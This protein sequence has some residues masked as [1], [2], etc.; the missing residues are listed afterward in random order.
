MTCPNTNSKEWKALMDA[1]ITPAQAMKDYFE[2]GDTIRT[3]KEVLDTIEK[4]KGLGGLSEK[5][6]D[7]TADEELYGSPNN[8]NAVEGIETVE[9]IAYNE[10]GTEEEMTDALID[11]SNNAA[12]IINELQA[13]LGIQSAFIT[14]AEAQEITANANNPYDG[15]PSFFYGDTVY[16][17]RGKALNP[18]TAFHEFSHP[19]VRTIQQTNKKL[20]D[21]LYKELIS[22]TEGQ[23]ILD[24]IAATKNL[25]DDSDMLQEEV[26]VRALAQQALNKRN[27]IEESSGF[28]KF[29][30]NLLYA[31]KQL[32][33][34]KYGKNIKISKLDES[35]TLEE[36][37]D[38][39]IA[40][41]AIT[42]PIN[43]I[44]RD[45]VVSYLRQRDD[46][47]AELESLSRSDAIELTR[48][49]YDISAKQIQSLLKRKEFEELAE[50]LT[51]EMNTGPIQK[52]KGNLRQFQANVESK[53]KTALE[54]I[55][56]D[57]VRLEAL[58]KS[59]LTLEVMMGKINTHMTE[60]SKEPD[61]IANMKKVHHYDQMLSYWESFIEEVNEVMDKSNV[62]PNSAIIKS[63]NNINRYLDRINN[64]KNDIYAD[65]ARETLYE[66]LEPIGRSLKQKY[67]NMLANLEEKNAP[68]WK[69]DKIAK[70]YY[71]LTQAENKRMESLQAKN[72][73][74][75]LSR[76][77]KLELQGLE[78]KSANGIAITREKIEALL[79]GEAGDANY[80]NS[81]FEGYLY[82][83]DPIVGGLALYVKN[84]MNQVMGVA[85]KKFN[86]FA[87]DIEPLL[88]AA[89]FN[90]RKIGDLGER[91]GF[92][93]IISTRDE[94]G[95]IIEKEVLT[96]LNP[97]KNW[98]YDYDVLADAVEKA[99]VNHSDQGTE[100]SRKEMIRAIA[101]FNDFKRKYMHD[102]FTADYY[103]R[104]E[105]FE[106]DEIGIE[107]AYRRKTIMEQINS[108]V[109][110][111]EIGEDLEKEQRLDMLW[112]EYRQLSSLYY[113]NG[114]P[115]VDIPE[116]GIF[117]K[118]IALRIKEYNE[119]TKGMY[120]QKLRKDVFEN[121][122][123]A[124]EI[125]LIDRGITPD[126]PT[127]ED[128]YNTLRSA[129]IDKNIV[130]KIKPEWFE[131]RKVILDNIAFI[132][133][134]LGSRAKADLD[135]SERW[136]KIFDLTA[137]FKDENGQPRGNQLDEGALQGIKDLQDEIEKIKSG[138]KGITGLTKEE[139]ADY[140]EFLS[141]ID[142]M[143]YNNFK[144]SRP[145]DFIKYSK[146]NELR[147]D[148]LSKEDIDTLNK[149][150][151]QLA[152][153]MSSSV[154]DDYVD[155]FNNFVTRF[156][157]EA[158]GEI[159]AVLGENTSIN[160]SNVNLILT[161]E[162][163]VAYLKSQS[164]EFSKWFTT[165]HMSKTFFKRVEGS[166]KGVEVTEYK[167]TY[168]WTVTKPSDEKYYETHT[169]VNSKGEEETVMGLPA[170]KYYASVLKS[171]FRTP[172]VVGETVDNR[173]QWLPRGKDEVDPENT[174]YINEKY[175]EMKENNKPLFELLEKLKEHHLENQ[176]GLNYRSRLYLDMPRYRKSNLEVWQTTSVKGRAKK[177]VNALTIWAQR[178]K[179][180]FRRTAD[181]AESG[182]NYQDEF[183][184]IR[185]DMFDNEQTSVP[186]SGLYDIDIG[187][188]S[189][190]I[191]TSMM[192]YML[193]AERQKALI[194]ASP[195][196]EAI[197]SVVKRTGQIK[198]PLKVNKETWLNRNILK[199][200]PKN[201]KG[202]K[203]VREK[204]IDNF[205]AREFEGETMTGAGANSVFL[206][207][208]ANKLF[209]RASFGFF[210]LNIPSALKNSYGAKFQGMI[211]ASAGKYY[212]HIEFQKGN[213]WSYTTMAEL[214][215]NN[216][217]YKKGPKSLRQQIMEIFDP[218]QDRFADKFGEGLSRTVLKDT[219]E[220]SWLYSPRKWVELQAT[221]QIFG[222][223]M[224]RQKVDQVLSDG[225]KKQLNYVDAWELNE[226][227]QIVLKQ[228]IDVRWNNTSTEHLMQD[229][230]T[231]E[232]IAE[233]Y[234]IPKEDVD[235]VFR[236]Y[237]IDNINE[238]VAK[239]EKERDE[240][241]ANVDVS[242]AKTPEE[243]QLL[244]D[245]IENIKS[246]HQSKIDEAKTITIK[247]SEFNFYKNKMQQVMNNLQG[248]YAK[249][250]QPEAQRYLAFRFLSYLRRYFTSMMVNRYGFSGSIWDPKPRLNPGMGDVQM[251]YYVQFLKTAGETVSK[252]GANLPYMNAEEKSAALKV[253]TEVGMLIS[254]PILMSALLGW[255]PDDEER[256]AKLREKSGALPFFMT[257]ADM[258][259][260]FNIGGWL[261]N[262]SLLL[263]YN[264]RTENEQFIPLPSMGLSSLTSMLDLKSIVFGPTVM[265]YKQIIEN[266]YDIATGG[267]K[268]YY[269]RTVGPYAWQQEGGN[270]VWAQFGRMLGLTGSSLD[271]AKG[272]KGIT[273]AQAMSK[274]K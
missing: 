119:L 239:I 148:K 115:K 225:T 176:K 6:L 69:K 162:S 68:Q 130:T 228:G 49:M 135:I 116:Q 153:M 1:G 20:F 113:L 230:E 63:I 89:G 151:N 47:F 165:N 97:H 98:R 259:R 86:S 50:F 82:S 12:E 120:D 191:T 248:T 93:D 7:T 107:A 158:L 28:K 81:F 263:L 201:K 235:E 73:S 198:D 244:K 231:F 84:E 200:L 128:Y 205:I 96:F 246:Y 274:A 124:Y 143:G 48:K 100:K 80:F 247:N 31:I 77:E 209:S 232:Q 217:L 138:Q 269:K 29:I 118:S 254:L 160:K 108:I 271:P 181:D 159:Q 204:A 149:L 19:F 136:K 210:A 75:G 13:R 95:N 238:K 22:T 178:V 42:I 103:K 112:R 25:S 229:G 11:D 227:K 54:K 131:Q 132:M 90:P 17:V 157:E 70:E 30:K 15:E 207:N 146:L 46:F 51:D 53:A 39:L 36:L 43:N 171:K 122:L 194:K 109:D 71:G 265:S 41:D 44:S 64:T 187:D 66:Q 197:Q 219:A 79:K 62:D 199:F 40:A 45:D 38:M 220:F 114:Q 161:N 8:L 215:F 268:S 88:K 14:E 188:V 32:F 18:E 190:D 101:D 134:K 3:P 72:K 250:D 184:L 78:V 185:A 213:A 260:P 192:R 256:F 2:H 37:A 186:I 27:N 105:L 258:D 257:N 61:S 33:R 140:R 65:G 208:F 255:D 127:T 85:Q 21:R 92:R 123:H 137:G 251:G 183:N 126:N 242:T 125:S 104:Q 163:L 266:S 59:V 111:V 55:Q 211:E 74:T 139:N 67:E 23:Q 102:E 273:T 164:P 10:L 24:D 145:D 147:G 222:G 121:S 177:R 154:T 155:T 221:T 272:M 226:D 110:D 172:R 26:V 253:I 264:I 34:N 166:R 182:F 218:S 216:Q 152:E 245:K 168:A 117:D 223:M 141:M 249:F 243:E 60:L 224:Y 52:I 57:K 174:K 252:L 234:N 237:S 212:N 241:V 35:T 56:E 16:F 76:A 261:E 214:S 196:A 267:T 236:K 233:K 87:N 129:W 169:I 106:K 262:H 202:T 94:N 83:A 195:A 4:N 142:E 144:N 156:N 203:S 180:F 58:V 133:S 167:P 189:T 5:D 240:K 175:Y 179:D 9:D 206:N 173:G 91:V 99:T 193:S 270:K 170:R 150:Y